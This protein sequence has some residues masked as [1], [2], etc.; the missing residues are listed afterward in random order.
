MDEKLALLITVFVLSLVFGSHSL[1]YGDFLTYALI[2]IIASIAV[3]PHE[4]AHRWS[5]RKMGCYSRY[6][7]S[8]FGLLLT[9][10]TAIPFIP[11]KIIMPGFTL[12]TPR[13]YD[14]YYLKRV[15]G[16]TSYMGPLTNI[17][18]S[19]ASLALLT[20]FLKIGYLNPLLYVFLLLST[21]LNAWVAFFNLLPVPPLD[22]S[23][24]ITWN[25]PLWI[26]TFL[27]AIGLYIV[28]TFLL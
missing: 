1:L 21:R 5:A 2:T 22:G 24:I 7:L 13:T 9:L 15:M 11:F 4:L 14:P 16:I 20:V 28:S 23:K 26:A 8:P 6:V 17:L 18:F 3:I 19:V 12:V 27:L 10:I 25:T